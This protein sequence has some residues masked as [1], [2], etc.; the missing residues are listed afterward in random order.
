MATLMGTTGTTGTR[1][2]ETILGVDIKMFGIDDAILAIAANAGKAILDNN[3]AKGQQDEANRKNERQTLAE[4]ISTKQPG[5][6]QPTSLWSGTGN[7]I[8]MPSMQ[9]YGGG[10]NIQELLRKLLSGN[11]GGSYGQ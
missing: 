11:T 5:I 7:A 1:L 2:G 6:N 3:Q 8:A 10:M 4:M 9:G